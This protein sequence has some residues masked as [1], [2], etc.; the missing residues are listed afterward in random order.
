MNTSHLNALLT[1]VALGLAA[2]TVH[3]ARAVKHEQ[4]EN[5]MLR[6]AATGSHPRSIQQDQPEV[7]PPAR[8]AAAAGGPEDETV[9]STSKYKN[10]PGQIATNRQR[11]NDLRDPLARAQKGREFAS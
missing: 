3:Y 9:T 1:A 8:Q 5:Q 2:T 10:D 6:T 4:T 11:L 7:A